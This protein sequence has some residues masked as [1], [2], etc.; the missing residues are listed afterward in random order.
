MKQDS[1]KNRLKVFIP[2]G[3]VVL[4]ILTGAWYWYRDYRKFMTTDDAHVEANNITVSSKILGRIVAIHADEGDIV[5]KGQVL[6]EIDSSDLLSQ[7]N[8]AQSV[9]NQAIAGLNQAEAKYASDQK[10]IKVTEINLER[11]KEDLER[12]RNQSAGGVI[13]QEQFDHVKKGYESASAQL[14]ATKA[15]LSV[16]ASMIGTASAAV[17]TA[18]AQIK[19]LDTQL[20]NTRLYAPA[21]GSIAKRWLMTG[22]I[23]Q[24]GQSVFTLT[25]KSLTWVVAFLEETRIHDIHQGQDVRF[26]LDAYPHDR[27]YGKIFYAG[28]T[29]ASIF[30]LIP[31]NNASGNFTKV[32]QRIP[33]KISIERA[34]SGKDIST[35]RIMPGMSA[36]VK[37]IR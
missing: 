32:T 15:Q 5:T 17:E 18:S 27:F 33:V 10:S 14:D 9:K 37:I 26:T 2:L 20:K 11:A 35:Y 22:D 24:A 3:I 21:D 19:V 7:R 34:E 31:A 6:V 8:Q 29:T 30:S 25:D 12:A 1:N 23:V 28:T 16:S 4:I 13:T 36:V